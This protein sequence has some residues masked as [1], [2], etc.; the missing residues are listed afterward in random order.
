M[1]N[2]FSG[3]RTAA[4]VENREKITA[5]DD[6]LQDRARQGW[7]LVKCFNSYLAWDKDI[8]KLQEKIQAIRVAVA[9]AVDGAGVFAEWMRKEG[10]SLRP[11]RCAVRSMIRTSFLVQRFEACAAA[12]DV[13]WGPRRAGDRSQKPL[14]RCYGTQSLQFKTEQVGWPCHRADGQRKVGSHQR[15]HCRGH[16]L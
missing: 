9:K 4:A 11:F 3:K 8:E 5:I 1:A 7:N 13:P 10:P 2:I 15:D 14:R 12:R 16:G 6:L